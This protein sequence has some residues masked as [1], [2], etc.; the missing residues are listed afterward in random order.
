MKIADTCMGSECPPS[1]ARPLFVIFNH[2][3]HSYPLHQK[4][5]SGQRSRLNAS[6]LLLLAQLSSALII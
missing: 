2:V 3:V 5:F 1:S 4:Y 6:T